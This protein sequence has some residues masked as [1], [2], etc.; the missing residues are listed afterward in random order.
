MEQG[1][2]TLPED[3]S[4]PPIFSEVRV[5]RSLVLCVCFV[6]HYLSFFFRLA[7]VL[8]VL[9]RY[10]DSDC[11]FGI[12][13]LFL[14]TIPQTIESAGL[15]KHIWIYRGINKELPYIFLF[16]PGSQSIY[17]RRRRCGHAD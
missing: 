5:T 14:C 6:D 2:L 8:S 12:F 11:P 13:K 3:L 9:L 4:S 10:T 16:N 15:R 17:G 1:L 7:I